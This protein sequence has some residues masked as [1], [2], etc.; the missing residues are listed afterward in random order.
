MRAVPAPVFRLPEEPELSR[1]LPAFRPAPPAPP[2]AAEA[3]LPAG[4]AAESGWLGWLRGTLGAAFAGAGA[5]G[6]APDA[7][8]PWLVP[9]AIARIEAWLGERHAARRG[10]AP[11]RA[12]EWGSGRSTLWLARHGLSVVSIEGRADWLAATRGRLAQAGLAQ[13]VRFVAVPPRAGSA[14]PRAYAQ[15]VAGEVRAS[16]D[17]V[18]VDGP[19][20]AA[21]LAEAPAMLAPGGLLVLDDAGAA[22]TSAAAARL[23]VQPVAVFDNGIWQTALY[24]APA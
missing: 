5:A 20:R 6:D 4:P 19:F 16:F 15:A 7:D 23:P 17:L 9:A 10:G 13:Q 2:P 3:A 21:C 18:L 22:A 14:L 12:L 24:Q 8:Q 1:A 11:L